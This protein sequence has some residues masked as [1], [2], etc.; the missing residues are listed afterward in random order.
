MSVSWDTAMIDRMRHATR[1]MVDIQQDQL[2]L[3]SLGSSAER[4]IDRYCKGMLQMVGE[5]RLSRL[6]AM[7][8]LGDGEVE[9]VMAVVTV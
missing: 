2:P 5:G 9:V 7:D 1:M 6:Q 4:H 8:A 3:D